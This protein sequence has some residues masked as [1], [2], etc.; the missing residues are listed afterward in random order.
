MIALQPPTELGRKVDKELDADRAFFRR[1]PERQHRI[2]RIFPNERAQL[3]F[4]GGRTLSY[5]PLT[6]AIFVGVKK[7]FSHA[8]VRAVF[9]APRDIETDLS[10]RE[11]KAIFERA[12]SAQVRQIV[13]GIKAMGP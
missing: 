5:D 3:E 11:A 10:E 2:R 9:I 4:H 13:S 6:H 8:R 1:W 12:S 7:I